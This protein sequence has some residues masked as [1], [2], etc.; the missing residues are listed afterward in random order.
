LFI[1]PASA[2]ENGYHESFN[3]KYRD[4]LLNRY[5]FT[6]L[7]EAKVLIENWGIEYNQIRPHSS[8][9]YQNPS[10]ETIQPKMKI[11]T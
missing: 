10:P 9:N 5:I 6:T 8:L 1:E 4:Q 7:L 3:G 2:W 11:L